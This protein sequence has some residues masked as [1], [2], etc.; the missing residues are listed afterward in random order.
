MN[1]PTNDKEIVQPKRQGI[2]VI[3]HQKNPEHP[4]GL[5]TVNK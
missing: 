4:Q 5:G 3:D 1:H 2:E